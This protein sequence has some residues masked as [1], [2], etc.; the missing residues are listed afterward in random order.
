MP[1]L[2][3]RLRDDP[4][5]MVRKL[6]ASRML[7]LMTSHPDVIS[8]RQAAAVRDRN[9]GARWAARYA[10]RRAGDEPSS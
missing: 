5:P 8:A 6:I 10:L 2:L 9:T 7:P 1:A 3:D 4:N